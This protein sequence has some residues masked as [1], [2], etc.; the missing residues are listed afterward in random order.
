MDSRLRGSD[1]ILTFYESN[2]IDYRLSVINLSINTDLSVIRYFLKND[3][4][5]HIR[6]ES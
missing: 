5:G 6:R 4:I 3:A 2:N 1:T